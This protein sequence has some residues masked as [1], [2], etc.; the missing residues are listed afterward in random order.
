ML[1]KI[2]GIHKIISLSDFKNFSLLLLLL[3]INAIFEVV[4]IGSIIPVYKSIIDPGFFQSYKHYYFQDIIDYFSLFSSKEQIILAS[5]FFIII[6]LFKT[7]LNIVTIKYN[8]FLIVNLKVRISLA[9]FKEYATKDYYFFIQNSS[10]KLVTSL[11][12]E[13]SEFCDRFLYSILNII[14][15]LLTIFF[16]IFFLIYIDLLQSIL[17]FVFFGFVFFIYN[18]LVKKTLEESAEQR[19]DMDFKKYTILNNFFKSIKEIKSNQAEFYFFKLFDKSVALF[20]KVFSKFLFIQII[21]KPFFEFFILL[22]LVV[23]FIFKILYNQNLPDIFFS[24][25]ILFISAFRG[26]PCLF[27]LTNAYSNMKF[28]LP[29]ANIVLSQIKLIN[30]NEKHKN[31]FLKKNFY[32]F[33][34]EIDF[35]NVSFRYQES[36]N[37]ILQDLNFKLI[38][39]QKICIVGKSGSGKSTF[40]DLLLGLLKPTNGKIL[41]DGID[42]NNNLNPNTLINASYIPQESFLLEDTI[43][44]N[45]LLSDENL[46]QNKFKEA[47]RLSELTSFIESLPLKEKTFVGESGN[48][49]SGGQK[50]RISIARSF[51]NNKDFIIFDE[52]LN[53]LEVETKKIIFDNIFKHFKNRTIIF[54]LHDKTFLD[55]FDYCYQIENKNINKL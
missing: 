52:P 27:R 40:I 55:Y 53:A 1:K 15:E 24:I 12:K 23:F 11:I 36:S 51:Y 10:S 33:N 6:F 9:I 48:K 19:Q 49:F 37:N 20:E 35:Q 25:T 17:F 39:G 3:I 8:L 7:I 44:N 14:L 29:S 16:I 32:I 34:K 46:N 28:S 30:K 4:S 26:V 45:I 2:I 13:V 43:E 54:I 18:G 47:I 21:S 42:I 22:A 41:I 38:K 31:F 5:L 50:Q